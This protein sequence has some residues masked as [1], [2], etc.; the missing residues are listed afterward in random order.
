M[1]YHHVIAKFG[2]DDQ[3]RCLFSDLSLGELNKRFLEPYGQGSRIVAGSGRISPTAL[4]SVRI[5]RT[6]RP[7]EIERNEIN[8]AHLRKI[9]GGNIPSAGV[10]AQGAGH[11]YEPQDIAEAGEDLTD[12]L[13]QGPPGAHA[14][15][16]ASMRKAAGWIAAIVVVIAALSILKWLGWL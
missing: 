10:T 4:Q 16:G 8:K 11:G 5:I 9:S 2:T 1:S 6:L 14:S 3:W 12:D 15:G 13:I 7:E